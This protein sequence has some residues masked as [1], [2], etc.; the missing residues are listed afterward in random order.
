MA[1]APHHLPIDEDAAGVEGLLDHFARQPE[2]LRQKDIQAQASRRRVDSHNLPATAPHAT[3][4]RRP[5]AV[6][7]V[8]RT[9]TTSPSPA[10]PGKSTVR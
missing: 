6:Q 8:T 7:A 5:A 10:R 2:A 4:P 3:S 1:G 9:G